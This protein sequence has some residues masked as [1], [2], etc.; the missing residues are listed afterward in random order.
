MAQGEHQGKAQQGVRK[1]FTNFG[2]LLHGGPTSSAELRV[3][4]DKLYFI[5]QPDQSD[6]LVRFAVMLILSAVIATGGV[7]AD[8]TAAV[9][10]AMIIAPLMTPIMAAA[11]SIST[12]RGARFSRSLTVVLAGVATVIILSMLMGWLGIG[13]LTLDGN[14]QVQSRVS[15]NLRDMVIAL[16]S[17]LAGA[18]AVT[19]PQVGD[20]LP[21][22]AISISLVPPLCVTGLSIAAGDW[23]YAAGS[24]LL[25]ATN[26]VAILVAGSALFL[27]VGFGTVRVAEAKEADK[28][29]NLRRVWVAMVLICIPLAVTSYNVAQTQILTIRINSAVDEWVEGTGWAKYAVRVTSPADATITVAGSG[30]RPSAEEL[31]AGIE[32]K[33]GRQVTVVVN[34]VPA[35]RETF[36]SSSADSSSADSSSF[37]GTSSDSTSSLGQGSP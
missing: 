8:S 37:D 11:L 16:A 21:G 30:P 19:R 14:S 32:E 36:D 9:I 4:D 23:G 20:A 29:R 5:G 22:V 27:M 1:P 28:K 12:A 31:V 2:V 33:S 7:L 15:P 24:G 10:G 26:F 34:Y 13:E 3:L 25:F 17:G 35:A 6:R 18:F